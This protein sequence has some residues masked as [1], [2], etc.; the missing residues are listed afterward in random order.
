MKRFP[1]MPHW[2]LIER[3]C[4]II[5]R[6]SWRCRAAAI[7]GVAKCDLR[8][9]F[10][11]D[12]DGPTLDAVHARLKIAIEKHLRAAEGGILRIRDACN[13]V[14]GAQDE[15]LQQLMRRA[16]E[17]SDTEGNARFTEFANAFFA[18]LMEDA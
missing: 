13:A 8:S 12:L 2:Q 10:D 6:R 7:L 9:T 17:A 1:N 15:R 11:R 5:A 3:T 16:Q 14:A 18:D 4:R